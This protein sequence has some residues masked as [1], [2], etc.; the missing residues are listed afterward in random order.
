MDYQNYNFQFINV[1]QPQNCPE[2][3][4]HVVSLKLINNS[5]PQYKIFIQMGEEMKFNK[6]VS[7]HIA[8]SKWR[9]AAVL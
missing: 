1:F 3:K 2:S 9:T 8:P 5:L 4:V 6:G 7:L